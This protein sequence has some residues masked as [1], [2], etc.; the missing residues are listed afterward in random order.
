MASLF[1]VWCQLFGYASC[2]S[3]PAGDLRFWSATSVPIFAL[4]VAAY[5]LIINRFA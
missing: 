1:D 5:I 3:I 2:H 4:V